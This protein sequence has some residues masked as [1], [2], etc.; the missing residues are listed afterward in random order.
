M[1]T[2]K[3]LAMQG[4][5]V[6]YI[7]TTNGPTSLLPPQFLDMPEGNYLMLEDDV[8]LRP[9]WWEE[10]DTKIGYVP[11]DWDILKLND[12]IATCHKELPRK[13]RL[14]VARVNYFVHKLQPASKDGCNLA[15][16]GA[17]IVRKRNAARAT[18]LANAFQPDGSGHI[19]NSGS[20]HSVMSEFNT[21]VPVVANVLVKGWGGCAESYLWSLVFKG[22]Q[23]LND[24]RDTDGRKHAPRAEGGSCPS[25]PTLFVVCD[26]QLSVQSHFRRG[27]PKVQAQKTSGSYY[28]EGFPRKISAYIK[29]FADEGRKFDWFGFEAN[30][31]SWLA[32]PTVLPVTLEI[33]AQHKQ[34]VAS[35]IG[36]NVRIFD[37]LKIKER[38]ARPLEDT[39]ETRAFQKHYSEI[40]AR[41]QTKIN[42]YF[43]GDN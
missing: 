32:C 7:E 2:S 9:D 23:N 13:N 12:A 4:L 6:S 35:H 30:M 34:R 20:I 39:T 15:G 43:E 24:E 25:I 27:W 11:R 19:A 29:S 1:E 3:M 41:T 40:W 28:P 26:P 33:A 38:A 16:F 22:G 14:L 17:I 21:F 8:L 31:D 36:A 18:E 10:L 42:R 37:K 5:S